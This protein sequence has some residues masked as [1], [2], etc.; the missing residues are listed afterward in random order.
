MD[1]DLTATPFSRRLLASFSDVGWRRR[2]AGAQSAFTLLDDGANGDERAGDGTFS[3]TLTTPSI[4]G[5]YELHFKMVGHTTDGQT[6]TREETHSLFVQIGKID[7]GRSTIR[8]VQTGGRDYVILQ[9]K[10]GRGNVLGPGYTTQIL[11]RTGNTTLPVEDLLDG[12]YRAPLPSGFNPN[13]NIRISLGGQVF[14]NA[15]APAQSLW[16]KLPWWLWLALLLLL[17]L[18]VIYLL[19]RP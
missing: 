5:H 12:R 9:P 14:H 2:F 1:P 3:K 11:I 10:D 4:P 6:F 7:P 16:E 13:Q 15:P 8:R 19:R 18:A 17:T